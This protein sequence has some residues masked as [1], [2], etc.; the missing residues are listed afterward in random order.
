MLAITILLTFA[1]F[2]AVLWLKNSL[3]PPKT[4]QN[5]ENNPI[6]QPLP[7]NSEENP[8]TI[9][10]EVS[11]I[12]NAEKKF[13]ATELKRVCGTSKNAAEHQQRQGIC[14]HVPSN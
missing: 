9:V 14:N 1:L 8:D 7:A 12:Q 4:V 11:Y 2:R 3:S 6:I 5:N 13:T 10:W